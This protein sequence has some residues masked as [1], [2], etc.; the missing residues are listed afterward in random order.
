MCSQTKVIE[1]QLSSIHEISLIKISLYETP[2]NNLK[3]GLI[4]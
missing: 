4:Y 1:I 3:E 2:L